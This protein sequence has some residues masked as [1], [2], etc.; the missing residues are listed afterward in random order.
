MSRSGAHKHVWGSMSRSAVCKW[1]W[2]YR[3]NL[4]YMNRSWV[5]EQIWGY[6]S[7]SRGSLSG[8]GLPGKAGFPVLCIS[9]SHFSLWGR[10]P[11]P[12]RWSRQGFK[13]EPNSPNQPG[14]PQCRCHRLGEQGRVCFCSCQQSRSRE[15]SMIL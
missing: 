2:G 3:T 1:V 6:L 12:N 7:G 13:W 9:H 14:C 8:S 5:P 11:V 4:G 10:C 15:S